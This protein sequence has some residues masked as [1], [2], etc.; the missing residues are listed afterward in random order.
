MKELLNKIPKSLNKPFP[1]YETYKQKLGIPIV[2]S[3]LVMIGIIFLNPSK[4]FDSFI[5]QTI[6]VFTYGFI[7]IL[8]TL[9]FSLILPEILPKSFN[10][11]KW[12]VKKTIIFIFL[13]ILSVG[14]SISLFAYYFDNPNTVSFPHLFFVVLIRAIM[15]SFFPIIAIVLYGENLLHKKNHSHAIEIINDLQKSKFVESKEK[16]KL[17]YTFAK[18][19]NDEIRV[20][21]NDLFYIK[22]EG[23]YCLVVFN[24][25]SNL[26]KKLIRSKLKEIEQIIEKSTHLIRCHKS[27]IIN[28]N[29]VS[30]VTGNA[31]GYI[32]H[33][34]EHNYKVPVSRNLSKSLINRIKNNVNSK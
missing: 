9:V 18:N 19:T 31:R 6:N 3:L 12:N 32:L 21:A 1:F 5:K 26:E 22:A 29:K 30:N 27:Y 13:S 7:T 33:L 8:I 28:L 15:L 2:F 25:V 16:K 24:N 11:E 10:S 17:F 34:N 23:N 4:D 14:V 20:S